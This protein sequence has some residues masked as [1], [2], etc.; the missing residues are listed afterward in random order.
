MKKIRKMITYCAI[1]TLAFSFH[2]DI[3]KA[4]ELPVAGIDL[5]LNDFYQKDVSEEINI[6]EYL[7]SFYRGISFAQVN[8]YVNIRSKA[9]EES[10]ILGKLYN[11]S[12]ATIL[13]KENDWYKVKSGTV[14]GYIKSE[15]LLT[16]TEADKLSKSEGTRIATVNTAT[17]YVREE[18][19]TDSRILTMVPIGDELKV[20]KEKEGWVKIS[21]EGDITGYV[22]ADYVKLKTEYEEAVSIQEELERLAEE[23]AARE[24]EDRQTSSGNGGSSNNEVKSYSVPKSSSNSSLRNQIVDYALRFVGNPYVWGGTSLTNGADCSGFTQS[25]L[26]DF[27]IYISRTS[28]SQASGG[29]RVSVDN[30]RPGDLVFYTKNGSINHVAMY[31]GNGQVISASSPDTGIRVTSLYYRSPYKA[32]NYI[33]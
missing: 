15:Y 22:S 9:N 30:V 6:T 28:R 31:I 20:L 3:T 23:Q 19:N 2:S 32:V 8:N 24:A 10:D 7:S 21:V 1:G 27:G 25:V 17:L 13:E 26:E 18:A 29:R 11:N 4:A 12:A 5:V 14:S 16:G 33:D